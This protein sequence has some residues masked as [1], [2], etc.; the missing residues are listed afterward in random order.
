MSMPFENIMELYGGEGLY[1]P[2]P[3]KIMTEHLSKGELDAYLQNPEAVLV[4]KALMGV[5]FSSHELRGLSFQK[6]IFAD[7]SFHGADLGETVFDECEFFNCDFQRVRARG[8]TFH[9]P[10]IESCQFSESS[11]SEALFSQGTFTMCDLLSSDWSGS[12]LAGMKFRVCMMSA[13]QFPNESVFSQASLTNTSFE[14][15]F[16]KGVDFEFALMNAVRFRMCVLEESCFMKTNLT[17]V[18]FELSELGKSFFDLANAHS[19]SLAGVDLSYAKLKH[20]RWENCD[21]TGANIRGAVWPEA[22]FIDCQ[23][24]G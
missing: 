23:G 24:I 10:K 13:K 18:T 1:T 19:C 22:E 14:Q 8:S 6:C 9:L 3:S 21:F 12:T 11:F 15:C 2:P 7:V 4:G 20:T 17:G 5:D 16:M